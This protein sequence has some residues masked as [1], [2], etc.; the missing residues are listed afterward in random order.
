LTR[1]LHTHTHTVVIDK[2]T[3]SIYKIW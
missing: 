3:E 1:K 2:D